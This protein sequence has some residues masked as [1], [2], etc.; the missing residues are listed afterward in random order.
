MS[1]SRVL[2]RKSQSYGAYSANALFPNIK[3]PTGLD[4]F[5]S[6]FDDFPGGTVHK[7][8]PASA[9]DMSSV[10][11]MRRFHMPWSNRA[12]VPQLLSPHT[13]T[14]EPHAANTETYTPR[15]CALQQEK[16][17]NEKPM[18]TSE[19]SSPLAAT[20]EGPNKTTK[21]HHRRK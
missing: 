17:L 18:H 12:H 11:S 3:F 16:P 5:K 7:N 19:E 15:A 6:G 1:D 21:T 14:I 9:G 4:S 2:K 20:T 13:A 8:L 10:P